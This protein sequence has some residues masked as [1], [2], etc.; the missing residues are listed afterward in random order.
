MTT[1]REFLKECETHDRVVNISDDFK[2]LVIFDRENGIIV[3]H[4]K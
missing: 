2:D 3:R 1:L 4:V